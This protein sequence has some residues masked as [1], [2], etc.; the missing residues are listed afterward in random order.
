MKGVQTS[1]DGRDEV[2]KG[3]AMDAKRDLIS[4]RVCPSY[5]KVA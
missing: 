2:K 5:P 4:R 1:V 3:F